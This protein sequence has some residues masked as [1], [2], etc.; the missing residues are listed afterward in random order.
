MARRST[1]GDKRKPAIAGASKTLP[2]AGRRNVKVSDTAWNFRSARRTGIRHEACLQVSRQFLVA[3]DTRP[4]SLLSLLSLLA[5]LAFLSANELVP[6]MNRPSHLPDIFALAPAFTAV[7]A[8]T[9]PVSRAAA[10]ARGDVP[11]AICGASASRLVNR[12]IRPVL[13]G[14]VAVRGMPARAHS[15]PS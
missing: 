9:A 2:V 3:Q 7:P 14:L 4:V 10:V 12:F 15:T 13:V 11:A 8:G 5:F 1:G 6:F